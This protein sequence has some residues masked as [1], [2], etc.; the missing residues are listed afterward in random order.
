MAP[1]VPKQ[2]ELK[3]LLLWPKINWRLEL[4]LAI[5]SFLSGI[6]VIYFPIS[7]QENT[8]K[9]IRDAFGIIIIVSPVLLPIIL[10]ICKTIIVA[11]VRS[12]DYSYLYH[13]IEQQN[14]E[15]EDLK[16][17]LSDILQRNNYYQECEIILA[18][19]IDNNI[20]ISI[21]SKLT[22]KVN[23]L[24]GVVD[25]R[26]GSLMGIFRITERRNNHY[27]AVATAGIEPVWK[28]YIVQ[29]SQVTMFPNLKAIYLPQGENHERTRAVNR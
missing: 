26:D 15:I 29:N 28:G 10:W 19:Y 11:I 3:P 20:Y 18:S 16:A 23:N 17:N 5:I 21:Q 7:P 6:F 13:H 12:C 27:Y 1:K 9:R 24:L 22:L 25:N 2:H 4:M 8:L 14:L